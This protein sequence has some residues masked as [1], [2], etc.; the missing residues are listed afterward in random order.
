MLTSGQPRATDEEVDQQIRVRLERTKILDRPDAPQLCFILSESALR[1]N[2]GGPSVMRDQL[3]FL[4]DAAERPNIELQLLPFDAQT[5]EVS[6]FGFT[7]LRFDHDASSDVVYL[8]DYTD[9]S[10]LDRLDAV[11]AYSKLWN[12]LQAAALGPVESRQLI[13]R[14]ADEDPGHPS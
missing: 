1:R 8:E 9:A 5:Y 4:A 10:Y 14:L 11:R 12:R 6:S 2:V 3:H 7:V 13:L